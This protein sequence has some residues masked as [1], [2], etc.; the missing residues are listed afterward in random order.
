MCLFPAS[1]NVAVGR[2]HWACGHVYT[3]RFWAAK[4]KTQIIMRQ[5]LIFSYGS[6]FF[7]SQCL[8]SGLMSVVWDGERDSRIFFPLLTPIRKHGE[9]NEHFLFL[10][11]NEEKAI[12]LKCEGYVVDNKNSGRVLE[13][14]FDVWEKVRSGMF[15]VQKDGT[16]S[17]HEESKP[18]KQSK[19]WEERDRMETAH[20]F[21]RAK[22]LTNVLR[23]WKEV[24]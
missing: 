3:V 12:C 4:E 2:E 17:K 8:L 9:A 16:L 14:L 15:F 19:K 5:R 21:Y 20:G 6:L 18:K 10:D 24:A 13:K 22:L 23:R 7:P 11:M 1:G